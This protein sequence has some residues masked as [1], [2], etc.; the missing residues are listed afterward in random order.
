MIKKPS[1]IAFVYDLNPQQGR[2]HFTR[3]SR[4]ITEFRKNGVKCYIALEEKHKNFHNK[5]IKNER[6]I[7]FEK[8]AS[9]FEAFLE[10]LKKKKINEH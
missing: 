2:G 6:P 10:T 8:T 5:K 1:R 4:L 3:T 9:S 7:Y